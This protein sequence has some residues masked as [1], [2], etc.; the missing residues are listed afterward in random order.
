MRHAFG[1]QLGIRQLY[2]GPFDRCWTRGFVVR[3]PWRFLP[4]V[5]TRLRM[6][7][8][9][10]CRL[11]EG[12]RG[13][14]RR[15]ARALATPAA[16][17]APAAAT[18]PIQCFSG[19]AIHIWRCAVTRFRRRR[20]CAF[21]TIF[22]LWNFS[23]GELG[24]RFHVLAVNSMERFR[25]LLTGRL[26]VRAGTRG[27]NLRAESHQRFLRFLFLIRAAESLRGNRVPFH[28]FG[29]DESFLFEKPQFPCD[30]RVAGAL[31]EFGEF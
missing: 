2:G 5:V 27:G 14:S 15:A 30:H 16:S 17:A 25:A 8:R 24:L 13:K 1:R 22:A 26:S 29:L 31:I 21:T 4:R 18:L 28:C 12:L 3:A 19:S 20:F 11:G 9:R 6:G 7:L 10:R 23:H